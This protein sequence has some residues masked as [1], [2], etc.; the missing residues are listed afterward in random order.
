MSSDHLIVDYF[1]QVLLPLSIGE[2]HFVTKDG[3]LDWNAFQGELRE[4][5]CAFRNRLR[6]KI[7]WYHPYFLIED[8]KG[9][10]EVM[11]GEMER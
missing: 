10:V 11:F 4:V 8:G 6:V 3:C 9:A 2:P 7:L 5:R 1:L